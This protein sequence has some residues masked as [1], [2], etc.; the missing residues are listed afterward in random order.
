MATQ[1]LRQ[2]NATLTENS[3]KL[4]FAEDLFVELSIVRMIVTHDS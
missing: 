3:M 1:D 4:Y 2:E